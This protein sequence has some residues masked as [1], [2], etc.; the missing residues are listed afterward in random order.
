[1][2]G[3]YSLAALAKRG[4]HKRAR[5]ALSPIA[6]RKSDREALRRIIV[7][8]V[9]GG[10]DER[11]RLLRLAN[12]AQVGITQDDIGLDGGIRDFR[13]SQ[14]SRLGRATLAIQGWVNK[15]ASRFDLRWVQAVKSALGVDISPLVHA[16]DLQTVLGL[17]TQKL[18]THISGL[19]SDVA[20]RIEA[21][22]IDLITKGASTKAKAAV[23]VEAVAKARRAA[24]ATAKRETETFNAVLNQFRQ[25]QAGITQ[26]EW[27]TRQDERVRGR[28]GGLYPKARPSH[29]AR[30]GRIF[31]WSTPP[32]DG[33]PGEAHG[34]RCVA[35][36]VV[37]MAPAKP[38][39]DPN[40]AR[41]AG[42]RAVAGEFGLSL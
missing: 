28:P 10:A 38:M 18:T 20:N 7:S 8:V 23:M 39:P 1:M 30:Q 42:L 40:R 5:T 32:E 14:Q 11:E 21:G 12:A 31:S 2:R 24:E 9:D 13:A 41:L 17:V 26:Y 16:G 15:V 29:W 27:W 22:L 33:H 35:R 37:T 6:S 3:T 34:C 36:P 19:A 25:T 4:G